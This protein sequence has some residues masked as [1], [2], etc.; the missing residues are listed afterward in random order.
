LH[1]NNSQ[2]RGPYFCVVKK[3]FSI[4]LLFLCVFGRGQQVQESGWLA[5]FN[6]IRLSAKTSLHAELQLRSTSN[7][8]AVQTILPRIG[9]NWMVGKN[10]IL[11]AGY[12]YIPN[13]VTVQGKSG[14]L[15][16]HRFWQQLIINQSLSKRIGIQHR[17]RLEERFI[18]EGAVEN[19]E[20]QKQGSFFN[21]RLRY[22]LRSIVPLKKGPGAFGKGMFAALQNEIFCN[23]ANLDKVNGYVF[24]Q[25]RAYVAIGYRISPKMD[26]ETGYMNQYT[27]R[28]TSQPN[29]VNHILQL[30]FYTRL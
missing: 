17:F 5:S 15:A 26:I 9:I 21:A 25:N 13:R 30:A 27:K 12:A 1:A 22:F 4:P 2:K 28:K 18:P 16:E 11:T 20:L 6:T 8:A 14:L 10:E 24:D 7:F 29:T 23:I 3:F 19:G